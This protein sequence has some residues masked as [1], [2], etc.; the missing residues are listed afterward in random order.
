MGEQNDG[1]VAVQFSQAKAALHNAV[2]V[3][4]NLKSVLRHSGGGI[5]VRFA[6]HKAVRYNQLSVEKLGCTLRRLMLRSAFIT[7]NAIQLLQDHHGDDHFV[8]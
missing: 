5:F 4:Q 7:L 6:L 1:L 2:V 3:A 8:H